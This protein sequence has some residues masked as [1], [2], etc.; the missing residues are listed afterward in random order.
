MKTKDK[1]VPCN[2]PKPRKIDRQKERQQLERDRQAKKK[3]GRQRLRD[4][5]RHIETDRGA[6]A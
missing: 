6:H 4:K 2:T 5:L 1:D 3:T